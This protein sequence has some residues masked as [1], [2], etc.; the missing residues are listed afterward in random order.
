MDRAVPLSAASSDLTPALEGGYLVRKADAVCVGDPEIERD[1]LV[2]HTTPLASDAWDDPDAFYRVLNNILYRSTH[3]ELRRDVGSGVLRVLA[4]EYGKDILARVAQAAS[5]EKE[6]GGRTQAFW[7]LY[8]PLCKAL[9]SL[10]VSPGPLADALDPVLRAVGNDL[11]N[12]LIYQAVEDFAAH[13]AERARFLYDEFVGRPEPVAMLT[14]NALVALARFGLADAHARALSLTYSDPP[15]RRAGISALG[16]LSYA[17]RQDP[18]LGSTL[19]RFATLRGTPDRDTDS[20]L[21]HAYL[22]LLGREPDAVAQALVELAS[23][24]DPGVQHHV[25]LVLLRA[26]EHVQGSPWYRNALFQL[27]GVPSSSVGTLQLLD[28]CIRRYAGVDP[29]TALAF[30]EAMVTGRD[31]GHEGQDARL[32]NMLSGTF[33]LLYS[34][35]ADEIEAAITRWFAAGDPRL[36]RA[37]ADLVQHRHEVVH[38]DGN[39]AELRL[40]K[41]VLDGL[42]EPEVLDVVRRVLGYVVTSRRLAALVLSAA[43][44]EP[45]QPSVLTL[46]SEALGDYVLYNY[47]M[48]AGDYLRGRAEQEDVTEVER[49]AIRVALECS[50]A[51]VDAHTKLR[52]LLELRPSARHVYLLRLAQHRQQVAAM[53][54]ANEKSVFLNLVRR[55]PLKYGRA[56]FFEREGTF[57]EPTNLHTYSHEMEMPRGELVDPLGQSYQRLQWRH[58]GL[59]AEQEAP[60]TT[61]G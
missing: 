55:V 19:D 48:E 43:R 26:A 51:Y 8:D 41:P 57:S 42:D 18:L 36:H 12:G 16:R 6:G 52:P 7:S 53:E 50:D 28:S 13:S 46:V 31:Y 20:A 59:A 56:S 22:D 3:L 35:H 9:P 11:T 21:A 54:R 5:T 60:E 23:R 27:N 10:D 17:A 37:A 1:Y 24:T 40:S 44:R 61:A 58:A 4:N 15:V 34:E 47:P 29:Q 32:P 33:H 14:T 45:Q 30:A 49:E 39:P 25:A 2:R 38:P